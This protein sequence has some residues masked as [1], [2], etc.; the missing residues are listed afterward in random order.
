M[1]NTE[2]ERAF[3]R[4]AAAA[5]RYAEARSLRVQPDPV[6]RRH[7]LD[8]LARNVLRY[9]RPYCPCREVTGDPEKDRVNI[10]PCRTHRQEIEEAGECECALYVSEARGGGGP[11]GGRKE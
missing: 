1:G 4:M 3:E 6:L 8:G 10:C 5:E 7:V 9:G 11:S 2:F